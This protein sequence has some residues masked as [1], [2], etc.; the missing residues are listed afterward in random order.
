MMGGG[1]P[2]AAP[3]GAELSGLGNLGIFDSPA[4]AQAGGT[5]SNKVMWCNPQQCMGLE[6]MGEIVVR[7]GSSFMEMDIANKV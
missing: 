4:V 3:A 1:M 7:N 5:K 6:V 2:A